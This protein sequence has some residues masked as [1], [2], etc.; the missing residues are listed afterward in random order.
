MKRILVALASLALLSVTL[1]EPALAGR[2]IPGKPRFEQLMWRSYLAT[3]NVDSLYAT[4]GVDAT[5][6]G[7]TDTSATFSLDRMAG[8]VGMNNTATVTTALARI[9]VY[10]SNTSIAAATDSICKMAVQVSND[11][12]TWFTALAATGLI[13]GGA[14]D[15]L[16]ALSLTDVGSSTVQNS[17]MRASNWKMARVIT[18]GVADRIPQAQLLLAY[19]DANE[20]SLGNGEEKG[21]GKFTTQSIKW[22]S[23]SIDSTSV[24]LVEDASAVTSVVSKGI[25][26]DDKATWK[27]NVPTTTA[28]V[29]YAVVERTSNGAA[30]VDSI[31]GAVE[32]SVD[33]TNWTTWTG[34]QGSPAGFAGVGT[35]VYAYSI[36]LVDAT[37]VNSGTSASQNTVTLVPFIRVRVKL[38]LSET[39]VSTLKL[40]LAYMPAY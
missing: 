11:G 33:G 12:S 35:G 7:S 40:Y 31:Y 14:G 28:G 5:S 27:N 32:C 18:T 16:A 34:Y 3:G 6:D 23:N 17:G 4:L 10:S 30:T 39:K 19:Y 29:V 26:M 15:R 37:T 8:G 1:A 9:W 38:P 13:T 20:P 21:F 24:A 25:S 2:V 36:P 22:V